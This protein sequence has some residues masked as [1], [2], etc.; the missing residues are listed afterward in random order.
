M[1]IFFTTACAFIFFNII[2]VCAGKEEILRII[3]NEK[4]EVSV[5]NISYE[6]SEVTPELIRIYKIKPFT[7]LRL[8]TI[9]LNPELLDAICTFKALE[10]LQI[11]EAPEGVWMKGV[12]DLE[13]LK[14]LDN[15]KSIELCVKGVKHKDITFLDAMPNIW[16][17]IFIRPS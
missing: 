16:K 10:F 8:V 11:G 5:S 7:S 3:T 4:G 2:G 17:V 15:L 13:K 6:I 14:K 9:D 12:I 1:K